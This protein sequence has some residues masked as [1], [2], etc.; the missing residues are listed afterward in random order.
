MRGPN[1]DYYDAIQRQID[2]ES[3]LVREPPPPPLPSPYSEEPPDQPL[4]EVN[5]GDIDAHGEQEVDLALNVRSDEA[6]LQAGCAYVE[7]RVDIGGYGAVH[8]CLAHAYRV[9]AHD[10]NPRSYREAMA[11]DN[12]AE[13]H[14]AMVEEM[15]ALKNNGTWRT[16]YLPV[17]RKAIRSRWV[18]KVKHLPDS[19]IKR[20][21]A[22]VVAQGFSQR[23]GVDFD[24]TFAP[25]ARWVAV[26]TVLAL[27]AIED[28]YLESVDI[29]SAFLH[30]VID[31]ELYMKFPEGF[32]EEVPP[33]IQRQPREGDA[34][35]KL[36]RG[37]Y[38]LRQGANLWNRRLHQ[39]LVKIGFARITSDP[40]VYVYLKG[41]IRIIIPIHVDDMTLASQSCSAILKVINDL[42]KYFK[43]R[44]LGPTTGLLGVVVTR[45]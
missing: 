35:T 12:A 6:L 4:W 17:G 2:R 11:S 10:S 14:K 25:M 3:P 13:W 36:E 29:S 38:G 32:P 18:F 7:H 30:S 1:A 8:A 34:C 22:R 20:F 45:N 42:Q 9:G 27:A 40:C 31:M 23:P 19:A 5:V 41:D 21:K 15:N 33:D 26:R 43:L 39:V 44:H 28:M 24:E 37:I 16:V